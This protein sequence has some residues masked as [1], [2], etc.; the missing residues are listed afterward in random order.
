MEKKE[1]P[2]NHRTAKISSVLVDKKEVEFIETGTG[3]RLKNKPAK[4]SQIV[5]ISEIG[6]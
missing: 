4:K 6:E 3:F 5:C 1:F 2:K